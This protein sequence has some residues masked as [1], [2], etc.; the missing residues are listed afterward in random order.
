[1]TSEFNGESQ[2]QRGV[3]L[4][5]LALSGL[6]VTLGQSERGPA[7]EVASVRLSPPPAPGARVFYGP[8]RGGPGTSDPERITWSAA[9]L[10]SM[11]MAAYD[12]QG[13]R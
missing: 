10:L 4:A 7:F 3:G 12:M 9:S 5:I 1:M 8:P 6:G 11:L 2:L 13:F